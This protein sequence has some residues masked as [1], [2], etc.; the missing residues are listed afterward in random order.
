MTDDE[1]VA[2]RRFVIGLWPIAARWPDETWDEWVANL[3]RYSKHDV[4][5]AISH[6]CIQEYPPSWSVLARA[7]R[8]HEQRVARQRALREGADKW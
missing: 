7:C 2:V 3:D 6:V 8:G 1:W 5:S 4:M